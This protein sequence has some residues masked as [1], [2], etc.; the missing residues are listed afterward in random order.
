MI[1]RRVTLKNFLSFGD[2]EQFF[3][4]TENEALWVLTGPNGVG[5]SA[6]FDAITYCLF[7]QHRGGKA[8]AKSLIRH[9]SNGFRVSFEFE[10]NGATYRI[11]RTRGNST[12]QKAEVLNPEGEWKNVPN[13][14]NAGELDAW[15]VETLGLKFD[16][17][18]ASVLL[19]QG[20]SDAIVEATGS[21]RLEILKRIIDVKRFEE[22]SSRVGETTKACKSQLDNLKKQRESATE[23]TDEQIAASQAALAGAEARRDAAQTEATQ[24]AERIGQ[25]KHR[26]K[27]NLERGE[28]QTKLDAAAERLAR[29]D[30]IR[31]AHERFRD[32]S[33]CV[34][35]LRKLV[36]ARERLAKNR[37][38]LDQRTAAEKKLTADL[39]ATE[40]ALATTREKATTHRAS[41]EQFQ[42][43]AQRLAEEIK[44]ETQ[45]IQTA[46][47]AQKL[48]AELQQFRPNLDAAITA[49]QKELTAA[50]AA[51]LR[52]TNDKTEAETRLKAVKEQQAEFEKAGAIC[53]RCRQKVNEQH[54]AQERAWFADEIRKYAGQAD[55]AKLA[56]QTAKHEREA[57][58]SHLEDLQAEA[59]ARDKAQAGLAPLE[60]FLADAGITADAEALERQLNAKAGA[61]Q[62]HAAR[63]EQEAKL[64]GEAEKEAKQLD[65]QCVRLKHDSKKLADEVQQLSI[66][67]A[68]DDREFTTLNGQ[69]TDGWKAKAATIGLHEVAGFEKDLAALRSQQIEE[70]YKAVQTDTASLQS[71][72]QRVGDID[73][74]LRGLPTLTV[75]EAEAALQTAKE[76]VKKAEADRDS[77]QSA[78]T[79]LTAAAAAYKKLLADLAV[80]E[81]RHGRLSK[82]NDWL[83]K[84]GLQRELV[85][86]AERDIV[87]F[88]QET[89][90]NLSGG[91]LEIEL[92]E[93]GRKDDEALVLLVRRQNDPTPIPVKFLSGSQKFRVAVA[94]AVAIGKFAAGPA[95]ARPL[96]SVIIDE[97]FG[98]LDKDGLAAMH[99]ELVNLKESQS[100]KR[101]IL[102]SHQEEFTSRFPMGYRLSPTEG[103]TVAKR[104]TNAG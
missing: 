81:T 20:E 92:D 58:K 56:L 100:L 10:F 72:Q 24:A 78:V 79:S 95:S 66:L 43:D 61:Q 87:H 90:G 29:L 98:S 94:I 55:A 11:T 23:V 86:D 102:V 69:L 4:F 93:S 60:K 27:L 71:W 8:D 51:A 31:E 67:V 62:A 18:T 19:R 33:A 68:S 41:A 44:R 73:A 47:N 77:A 21:A 42:R 82:L 75:A 96:E 85:R 37:G 84:Q 76:A 91:D 74:E 104:F 59:K 70:Q 39:A 9:G 101:V 35:A 26:A 25:A 97:G 14:N 3:D 34:P 13:V 54:A 6:V 46:S 5:K 65:G 12:T 16:A 28:L 22:L 53:S 7:G 99:Q 89:L 63:A 36:E 49:A 103:G 40:A 80:A 57:A 15:V 88:A 32:L 38:V 83:G 64:A 48:R 45:W 50:D 30:E 2:D 52:A 17:F 1:P